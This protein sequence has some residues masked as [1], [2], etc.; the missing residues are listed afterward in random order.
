MNNI[1]TDD[2]DPNDTFRDEPENI[3]EIT[4]KK[5]DLINE[6]MDK[7]SNYTNLNRL[8][9][10]E[11]KGFFIDLIY[12]KSNEFKGKY[13]LTREYHFEQRVTLKKYQLLSS[14]RSLY[15]ISVIID[16]GDLIRIT[17]DDEKRIEF[18]FFG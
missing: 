2:T 17:S 13:N 11:S 4:Q 9:S 15:E 12:I 8:F 7:K 5:I 14:S 16:K 18:E 1:N 6:I 10:N 3:V